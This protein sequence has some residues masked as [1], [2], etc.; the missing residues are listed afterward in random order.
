MRFEKELT[1]RLALAITLACLIN[2]SINTLTVNGESQGWQIDVYT[3]KRPHN[4]AGYGQPSDSFEESDLVILYANVTYNGAGINHILVT[5]QIYG[6]SNP[7]YNMSLSRTASTNDTGEAQTDFRVMWSGQD[8]ETVVFGTWNVTAYVE[9]AFDFMTFKV[10]WIAEIASLQVAG[11]KD[12]P[13]GGRL[14]I[15][16]AF[17]TIALDPKNATLFLTVYDS[18]EIII[19]SLTV[20]NLTIDLDSTNFSAVLRIPLSAKVGVGTVNASL[21]APTGAL[22]SP[23]VSVSFPISPFGDVDGDYKITMVDISVAAAAFGSGP[24]D[25]RWNPLADVDK[26]NVVN[27]KDIALIAQKFGQN[28]RL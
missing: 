8:P 21:Y 28:Y 15:Q 20:E 25:A 23:G 24:N 11:G 18:S 14:E 1:L 5:F 17:T 27:L 4:G 7:L 9:N 16:L 2:L 10:G 26:N 19:G 13:Q 22:Y 6:P 12:P 3:Q